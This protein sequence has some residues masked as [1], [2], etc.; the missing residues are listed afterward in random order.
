[1]EARD[2]HKWS[3]TG[4][5][6]LQCGQTK[7]LHGLIQATDFSNIIQS[8][9]SS[10]PSY[11]FLWSDPIGYRFKW[12]DPKYRLQNFCNMVQ[13]RLHIFIQ[14]SNTGY[15][16]FGFLLHIQY[17]P[18]NSL[19]WFSTGFRFMWRGSVQATV[20]WEMVQCRLNISLTWSNTGYRFLWSVQ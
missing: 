18:Q 3:S 10:R 6:F 20:F 2:C 13:F 9:K 19:K 15:T 1:M 7:F 17:K 14:W 8:L 11:I 16:S 5:I 4:Y 12:Y